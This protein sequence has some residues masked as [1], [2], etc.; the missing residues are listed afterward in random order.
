M[1]GSLDTR[2]YYSGPPRS[3]PN[4]QAA[5][6]PSSPPLLPSSPACPQR[7][8]RRPELGRGRGGSWRRSNLRKVAS[9]GWPGVGG[10]ADPSCSFPGGAVDPKSHHNGGGSSSQRFSGNFKTMAT[11]IIG[12]SVGKLGD[13]RRNHQ[14]HH[15]HPPVIFPKKAKTG[16]GGRAPKAG[17][18]P[19]SGR[20]SPTASACGLATCRGREGSALGARVLLWLLRLH[21]RH[22][23]LHHSPCAVRRGEGKEEPYLR[24]ARKLGPAAARAR[25]GSWWSGISVAWAK[26]AVRR[27]A[28]GSVWPVAWRAPPAPSRRRSELPPRSRKRRRTEARRVPAKYEAQFKTIKG[29]LIS[30]IKTTN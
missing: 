4:F 12:L 3:P 29:G 13:A 27:R 15:I 18:L 25:T 19:V 5:P 22:A 24:P 21:R 23:G 17:H 28:L 14:H 1:Q 30:G 20:S 9:P 2:L 16:G 7:A 26:A 6:S 10:A 8:R 11:P